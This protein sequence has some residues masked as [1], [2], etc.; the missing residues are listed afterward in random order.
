V[1]FVPFREAEVPNMTVVMN[2]IYAFCRHSDLMYVVIL[3][4]QSDCGDC[5]ARV[6][7][8]SV[9]YSLIFKGLEAAEGSSDLRSKVL[10]CFGESQAS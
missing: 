4:H 10:R 8:A 6:N 7:G 2:G 3:R 9:S 1:V 5:V